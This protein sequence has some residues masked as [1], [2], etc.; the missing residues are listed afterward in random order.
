MK[1]LAK[2]SETS[3]N[4]LLSTH[5]KNGYCIISASRS[6]NSQAEN[7]ELDKSLIA[8]VQAAEYSYTPIYGGYKEKA[9]GK[10]VEVFEKSILI[11]N[12]KKTGKSSDFLK[13]VDF[14]TSLCAKYKQECF[15][16]VFPGKP[17]AWVGPDG[18]ILKAF[19]GRLKLN[20]VVQEYFSTLKRGKSASQRITFIPEAFIGIPCNWLAR[21]LREAQGEVFC[22]SKCAE[23]FEVEV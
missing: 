13:L 21:Q 8:D 18:K 16:A 9:A 15:A 22:K 2:L 14:M 3:V 11:Y 17:P 6:E 12:F 10:T 5:A 7:S 4:R 20:D 19:S 23:V 1:T